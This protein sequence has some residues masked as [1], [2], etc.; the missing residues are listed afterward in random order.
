M[1]ISSVSMRDISSPTPAIREAPKMVTPAIQAVKPQETV[2][3]AR[4]PENNASP[5]KITDAINQVNEVL[6][7][8]G[9][10][11]YAA[12]ETD[13]ET[14]INIVKFLDKSTKEVI[15]QFPSKEILAIAEALGKNQEDKGQLLYV[16]G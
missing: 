3:G 9:Q 4:T 10:N 14:G 2:V 8:K 5:E 13:K 11:L 7:A 1:S 12:L 6:A 15:S 16:S